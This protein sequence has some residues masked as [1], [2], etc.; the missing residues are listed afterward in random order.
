MSLSQPSGM[1]S[2]LRHVQSA[3]NIAPP[4]KSETKTETSR[5]TSQHVINDVKIYTLTSVPIPPLDPSPHDP[6]ATFIRWP[7]KQAMNWGIMEKH[8]NWFLDPAD[9]NYEGAPSYPTELEPPRGWGPPKAK[10]GEPLMEADRAKEEN[11][12]RCTFCRRTYGGV[13]AKSMWRRHVYD[14]HRVAMKNRRDNGE[15]GK[16]RGSKFQESCPV[17]G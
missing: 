4:S 1:R 15:K 3:M 10:R 8:P 11:R 7:F 17:S 12:L 5:L 14:K 2:P 6:S 9:F 13:N 16:G